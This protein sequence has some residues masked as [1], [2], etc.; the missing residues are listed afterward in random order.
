V[1]ALVLE[2][3]LGYYLLVDLCA[4]LCVLGPLLLISLVH[5]CQTAHL[6]LLFR[7]LPKKDVD[8]TADKL[9]TLS[10]SHF[11]EAPLH[12]TTIVAPLPSRCASASSNGPSPNLADRF[13]KARSSLGRLSAPGTPRGG[14]LQAG[15][16]L[17]GRGGRRRVRG[18]RADGCHPGKTDRGHAG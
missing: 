2:T 3:T 1:R 13:S 6:L 9:R 15:R 8:A 5:G 10:H 18:S 14:W 16:G 4:L 12:A 7:V 17:G 11:Q